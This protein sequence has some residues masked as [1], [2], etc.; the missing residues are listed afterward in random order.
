MLQ[1]DEE[2]GDIVHSD[3]PDEVHLPDPEEMDN[4]ATDRDGVEEGADGEDGVFHSFGFLQK[5]SVQTLQTDII[6]SGKS[7]EKPCLINENFILFDSESTV[8]TFHNR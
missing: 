6:V 5:R 4:E 3:S 2:P 7:G 8:C 1:L